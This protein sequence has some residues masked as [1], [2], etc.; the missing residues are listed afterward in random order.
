LAI[1]WNKRIGQVL[2]DKPAKAK[3][4]A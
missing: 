4:S 3:K 1:K 2:R